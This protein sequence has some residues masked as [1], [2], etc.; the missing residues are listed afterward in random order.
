[1]RKTLTISL[2]TKMATKVRRD[3]RA[4]GA[5]VSEY[6]RRLLRREEFLRQIEQS[7]AEFAAGKGKI[8]HSLK[9]LR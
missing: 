4:E 5:T 8:L 7:E 2:P 3:A 9:D 1:M 6:I